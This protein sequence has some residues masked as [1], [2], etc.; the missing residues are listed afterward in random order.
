ITFLGGLLLIGCKEKSTPLASKQLFADTPVSVP[1]VAGFVDEASG[2]ADSWVNPGFLWVEQDSGN[3]PELTLIGYDG[4]FRKK[5]PV[6]G[7]LNRDWE[8]MALAR[9][10]LAGVRYIYLADVGDNNLQYENYYIYRFPEPEVSVDTVFSWDKITFRY[11]DGSHNA[12]AVFVD[13]VSRDIFI[14]TKNDAKARLFK[15][16]YPQRLDAPNMASLV[17]EL[18]FGQAVS[19]AMSPDSREVIVKT[20]SSLYHWNP[21]NGET[22]ES[23]FKRLPKLL[24]YK[25]EIQG[26]AVCFKRDNT[27]IFTLSE[28]PFQVSNIEL[29][30]YKRN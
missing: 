6:W 2:I 19:A 23:T 16:S 28:R 3:P 17:G 25:S 11:P 1:I 9:G 14:I 5:I 22:I 26:E 20:Y 15:L 18:E 21:Q 24:S 12:E 30:F 13:D 7:A 4:K 8:D 10:P 29:N 27:G